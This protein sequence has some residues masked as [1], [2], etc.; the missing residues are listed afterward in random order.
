MVTR[1]GSKKGWV[2]RLVRQTR[3]GSEGTNLRKE[4]NITM[5]FYKIEAQ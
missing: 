2:L 3:T 5:H 1:D 4:L